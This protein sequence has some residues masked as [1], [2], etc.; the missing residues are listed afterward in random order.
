VL[1]KQKFT[2]TLLVVG[3]CILSKLVFLTLQQWQKPVSSS[4]DMT[5]AVSPST[6]IVDVMFEP[7]RLIDTC[8]NEATAYKTGYPP[9][10]V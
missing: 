10:S 4:A 6:F 5:V 7:G 9:T 8:T 1:P 2:T 3:R